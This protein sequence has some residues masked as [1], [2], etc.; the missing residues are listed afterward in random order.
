MKNNK[1]ER[2]VMPKNK[3]LIMLALMI[4]TFLT[5]IEGTVVSTALPKITSE[6]QGVERMSWVFSIYLLCSTT[7]VPIFGRLADLFGRKNIFLVGTSL[8]LLGTTLCGLAPNMEFLILFRAIQGIG[9]GAILPLANTVIGDIFPMVERAKMLGLIAG[10]WGVAGI[11]GPLVGGFFVDHISWR[12][13][14]WINLP[15]GFISVWLFCISWK[16]EMLKQKKLVDYWGALTFILALFSLLYAIQLGGEE[17]NWTSPVVLI[18]FSVSCVFLVLFIFIESR[19]D[20]PMIPLHLFCLRTFSIPSL[21]G[22]ITSIMYIGTMVY[23]PVWAQGVLG[24][25]ATHS[26]FLITPM[27]L[28]W[29]LGSYVSGKLIYLYGTKWAG[30]IGMGSLLLTAIGLSMLTISTPV[31]YIYLITSIQGLTFV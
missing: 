10:V 14:F 16:E 3:R 9:A 11:L 15:F 30:I 17:S 27:M 7:M 23:L 4:G 31:I 18:L 22:F 28:T 13:I 8:F 19:V 29:M 20:E 26:G 25:S 5:A 12:W 24:L 6:L 1:G 2:L 21:L